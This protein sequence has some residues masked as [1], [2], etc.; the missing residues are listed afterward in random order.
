VAASGEEKPIVL[1]PELDQ[2]PLT[3]LDVNAI[4]VAKIEARKEQ[5]FKDPYVYNPNQDEEGAVAQTEDSSR[6]LFP[7]QPSFKCVV[8]PAQKDGDGG[9][10]GV[11]PKRARFSPAVN[12]TRTKFC[13]SSNGSETGS[14]AVKEYFITSGLVLAY[15]NQFEVAVYSIQ[16]P[17]KE[18]VLPDFSSDYYNK[19][20]AQKKLN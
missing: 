6:S 16:K 9:D 7:A 15:H 8:G 18:A 1:K 14:R 4:T 19:L 3:T 11:L 2:L 17:S 5:R 20:I 13:S 12:F 10:A